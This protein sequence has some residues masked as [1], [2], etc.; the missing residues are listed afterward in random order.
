MPG[1]NDVLI[2]GTCVALGDRAG[3]LKGAPGAGKSDLALRFISSFSEH[4]AALVADDQVRVWRDGTILTAGPPENLAGLLEVRGIGIVRMPHVAAVSLGLI[5]K[6][7]AADPIPR[8][9]PDPLPTEE[10]LGCC[11]PV[12]MLNPFEASAPA[13]LKLALG[14]AAGA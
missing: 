2:H 13:K 1:A 3:L 10:L 7:S 12:L 14:G 9:P 8:L 11:V 6:L 4:G 5:V